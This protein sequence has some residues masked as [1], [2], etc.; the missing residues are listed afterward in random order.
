MLIELLRLVVVPKIRCGPSPQPAA[1][2]ISTSYVSWST[3]PYELTGFSPLHNTILLILANIIFSISL[4]HTEMKPFSCRFSLCYLQ[5]VKCSVQSSV[6]KIIFYCIVCSFVTRLN[7]QNL[8]Q[9]CLPFSGQKHSF[10]ETLV[11]EKF[12]NRNTNYHLQHSIPEKLVN[13][14][15]YETKCSLTW[16][17]HSHCIGTY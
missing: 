2:P 10:T 12:N 15:V 3:A 9:Y 17:H 13:W 14:N 6:L 7:K 11:K 8:C 4:L 16:T 5:F 1:L